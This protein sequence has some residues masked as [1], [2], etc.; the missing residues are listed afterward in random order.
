MIWYAIL[1]APAGRALL[2]VG[3]SDC[4]FP[5]NTLEHA[6]ITSGDATICAH[7]VYKAIA[8]GGTLIDGSAQSSGSIKGSYQSTFGA[9]KWSQGGFHFSTSPKW[10]E[11][12]QQLEPLRRRRGEEGRRVSGGAEGMRPRQRGR[13]VANY[14]RSFGK[15][16]TVKSARIP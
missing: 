2:P 16:Y 6:V 15:I 1:A 10:R 11:G 9:K 4:G 14:E 3:G 12:E 5:A 8:V 13:G 7:D